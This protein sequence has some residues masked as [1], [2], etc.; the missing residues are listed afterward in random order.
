MSL[1]SHRWCHGEHALLDCWVIVGSVG[2][3]DQTKAYI[4]QIQN[5]ATQKRQEHEKRK[6]KT[7]RKQVEYWSPRLSISPRYPQ[8]V[9]G[10]KT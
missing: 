3:Q 6:T 9:A 7:R 10:R 5:L 4:E 8:I 2:V 1:I